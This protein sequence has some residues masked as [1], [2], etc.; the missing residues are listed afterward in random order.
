MKIL[1]LHGYKYSREQFEG[2]K[3]RSIF[4]L[5]IDEDWRNDTM[6]H[7]YTDNPNKEEVKTV[8]NSRK[9]ETVTSCA[10]EHWTTKEQDDLSSELI[11]EVLKGI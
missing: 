2:Y 9:K 6:V 1:T 4:R 8:I 3:F 5:S 7:I 10:M 11:D